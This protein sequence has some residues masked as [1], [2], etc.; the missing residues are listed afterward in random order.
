[1]AN[2]RKTNLQYWF[3]VEGETEKMYMDYVQKLINNKKDMDNHVTINTKVCKSPY[4][5][6]KTANRFTSPSVFHIC[7]IESKSEEH[8]NRF[9]R[10]LW[11]LHSAKND[12]N[13]KYSVGYSNFT[14]ELWIILHKKQLKK[15]LSSRTD[16]LKY[17]NQ[18]Y[19]KH[20]S[21]LSDYKR[22]DNFQ[23]LLSEI[24]IDSIKTAIKNADEIEQLNENNYV[25]SKS[26]YGM[27]YYLE[28]P[29]L[30]IHNVLRTILKDCKLL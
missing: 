27:K 24:N 14:F 22:K 18:A 2:N 28:N 15:H 26:E 30:S 6:I 20:Y 29:S 4:E 17:I 21:S 3:T 5:F 10:I 9:S 25:K 8:L 1:M 13:I 23:K 19:S 11:E 12:K 16:Y 7:D